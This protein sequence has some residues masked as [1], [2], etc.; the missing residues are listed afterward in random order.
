MT[1]EVRL[2]TLGVRRCAMPCIGVDVALRCD[3]FLLCVC[4]FLRWTHR[5]G[6]VRERLC[7]G[8]QRWKLWVAVPVVAAVR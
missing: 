1:F 6:W 7:I 3:V 4:S 5:L 2:S 8:G